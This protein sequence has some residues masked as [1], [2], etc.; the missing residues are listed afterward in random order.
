MVTRSPDVSGVDYQS[1]EDSKFRLGSGN[2]S[3]VNVIGD[4]QFAWDRFEITRE[5]VR[6]I[7]TFYRGSVTLGTITLTYSDNTKSLLV[8]GVKSDS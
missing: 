8:S 2:Q 5:T 7:Y 6:D 4:S 1:L 3:V